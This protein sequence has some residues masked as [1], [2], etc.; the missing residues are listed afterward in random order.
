MD[1]PETLLSKAMEVTHSKTK[2]ST[3]VLALEDIIRKH[4]I[5]GMKKFRGRI[6]LDVNLDVLR[7]RN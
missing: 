1:L 5:S 4:E 3:V 7:K 6:N 2:T